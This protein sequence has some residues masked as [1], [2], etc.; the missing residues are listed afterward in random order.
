MGSEV[1]SI[2][3]QPP[4]VLEVIL[5][6]LHDEQSSKEAALVCKTF[7]EQICYLRKDKPQ[8]LRLNEEVSCELM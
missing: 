3:D 2:L 1:R 4:E 7:H 5:S 8:L 6:H